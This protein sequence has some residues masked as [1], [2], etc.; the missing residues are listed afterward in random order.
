MPFAL[1]AQKCYMLLAVL[2]GRP[3]AVARQPA[4][5]APPKAMGPARRVGAG[6][7][8]VCSARRGGRAVDC[9]GLENR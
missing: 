8:A 2:T 7:G 1:R 6:G 5:E 3:M 4:D 9:G